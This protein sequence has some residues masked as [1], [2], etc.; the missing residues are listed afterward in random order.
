MAPGTAR[1]IGNTLL[2]LAVAILVVNLLG[3]A[4]VM[5]KL[6]AARELTWLAL[7][8]LIVARILRRT[9]KRVRLVPS[10]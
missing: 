2:V 1:M 8:L 9:A 3:M 10:A 5:H 4:G 7:V 6:A